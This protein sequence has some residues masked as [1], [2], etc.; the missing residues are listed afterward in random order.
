MLLV[1]RH[2]QQP[3][4]R[5]TACGS[6][7]TEFY[8]K[9]AA[10]MCAPLPG[11]ARGAARTRADRRDAATSSSTAR[12]ATT[13]RSFPVPRRLTPTSSWLRAECEQGLAARAT[14]AAPRPSVQRAPRLRARRDQRRWA[15]RATS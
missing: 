3:R 6:T 7:A 13:C 14:A 1:H 2:R 4:R 10:E 5:R 8:L 9:S 11:P 12:R 15:T